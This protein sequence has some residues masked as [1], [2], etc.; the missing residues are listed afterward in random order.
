[1]FRDPGAGMVGRSGYLLHEA[2]VKKH[3]VQAR[4]LLDK[5][6]DVNFRVEQDFTALHLA[7]V[8]STPGMV[9]LLLE[10]GAAI[11]ARASDGMTPLFMAAALGRGEMDAA[12]PVFS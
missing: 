4:T 12:W 8:E 10:R 9:R 5:G 7:A 2:V 6:A 1:M 3:R 11:E